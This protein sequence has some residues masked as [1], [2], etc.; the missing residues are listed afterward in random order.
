MSIRAATMADLPRMLEIYRPFVEATT[1]SF[2]YT[3]PTLDVFTRRFLDHVAQFPWL[4][5]EEEGQ[6]L[7]YAYAGRIWERAAYSWCAESSIYLAPQARGRGVGRALYTRLEELLQR[8]GYR[9]LYA[10]ITE[11]N[12]NSIA[13]HRALGY[14]HRAFFPGCGHKHGRWLGVVWLEKQLLP[15]GNRKCFPQPWLNQEEQQ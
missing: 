15:W 13:F 2:E 8:Q 1:V 4:V 9:V 14:T 11:E 5:W 12:Q 6:V 7:G 3:V 10:V